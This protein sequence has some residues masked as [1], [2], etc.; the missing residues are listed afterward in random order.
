VQG[1]KEANGHQG[2]VVVVQRALWEEL[3]SA[4]QSLLDEATTH[5]LAGQRLLN[6][7][8][9][10]E[11][12]SP[13]ERERLKRSFTR[14]LADLGA[15]NSAL[16]EVRSWPR[17]LAPFDPLSSTLRED[18]APPVLVA[19]VTW[20]GMFALTIAVMETTAAVAQVTRELVGQNKAGRIVD[21]A[22]LAEI[23]RQLEET[24]NAL[25]DDQERLERTRKSLQWMPFQ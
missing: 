22:H 9:R 13:A 20:H 8:S 15:E 14:F 25:E 12:L 23:E 16:E 24:L 17:P 4:Y 3:T 6:D 21:T 10:G 18:D 19:N 7:S 2:K 11:A 1:I 5:A